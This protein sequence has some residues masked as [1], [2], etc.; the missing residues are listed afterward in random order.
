MRLLLTLLSSTLSI[1]TAIGQ[2]YIVN[3]QANS[4]VSSSGFSDTLF[5]GP[6]DDTFLTVQLP[7]DLP[8]P[9]NRNVS[10]LVVI[11][12]IMLMDS[13]WRWHISPAG[14]F[15]A[16][17][18]VIY[19]DSTACL[20]KSESSDSLCL[21]WTNVTEYSPDSLPHWK[22]SFSACLYDDGSWK[23]QFDT[24]QNID[25]VPKDLFLLIGSGFFSHNYM[26]PLE[27]I[28]VSKDTSGFFASSNPL[29]FPSFPFYTTFVFFPSPTWTASQSPDGETIECFKMIGNILHN[30]CPTNISIY[31][32]S[33]RKAFELKGYE[34]VSLDIGL[35]IIK[36]SRGQIK[37]ITVFH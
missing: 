25:S 32:V 6:V 15:N 5:C 13:L 19:P 10:E 11:D 12:G 22:L 16:G 31:D 14:F 24:I 37:K 21:L 17:L 28:Y 23:A 7:F 18:D 9:G 3:I 36:D 27:G 20:L 26:I 33:G 30:T 35:W 1:V 8:L 34:S 4:G 29:L 2:P